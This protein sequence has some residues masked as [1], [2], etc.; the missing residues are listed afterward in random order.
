M[1]DLNDLYYFAAVVDHGGF[2]PAGRALG[3][4][5][6]K[7]SRRIALLEERLGARLLQRSTR[8][9]SV[10][11]VGQRFYG[12]CKA[13]L[14]EAEAARDLVAS[15]QAEPR[16]VV[17]LS[18]PI[19]LLHAHVGQMLAG[20]M[21]RYPQVT[22]HLDATNRRVDLVGEAID[23][24][25]RVRPPP[26]EDSELVLRTLADRAQ[27][28]VASPT[29]LAE[30][31]E[32]RVP[33]ELGRLPSLALGAPQELYSWELYG[34]DEVQAQILHRPRFVTTD[35]LALRAAALAGVGV[36]QLPVMMVREPLAAGALVRLLP[37]WQPR[38][39]IIHAV[40]PSRRCLLPS[41][42]AL[43]DHLAEGF[44]AMDEE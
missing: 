38:R 31:G 40:Y 44:A 41:V 2:S 6:S 37:A 13:M 11:E 28:L 16:G 32:P 4:P 20:F 3:I 12:H 7:L 8:H 15:T 42:R 25:I 23:V 17:R 22:L 27:C 34:P 35:M 5:K 43:L 36:V 10:T 14:V 26:L 1:Q 30:R 21:G 19:A 33:A 29:L 9:F 18:C 24:A 39:E